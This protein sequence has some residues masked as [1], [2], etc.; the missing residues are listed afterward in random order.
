MPD[1]RRR[2][3]RWIDTN[4]NDQVAVAATSDPVA[5][6]NASVLAGDV[7]GLTIIRTLVD[8][9]FHPTVPGVA[10]GSMH[11]QIGAG[12]VTADAFLANSL[13]D[14]LSS[15]EEPV[16]GWMFKNARF[17]WDDPDRGLPY[18][19]SHLFLDI[20]SQRKLD[21]DTEV[22]WQWVNTAMAGASFA[23]EA[24]GLIRLLVKLP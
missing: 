23:V 18:D 6:L 9:S 17:C 3:T 20:H 22:Y 7:P 8:V 16:R 4:V 11:C 12:I 10:L 1:G 5:L 15:S 2:G 19:A 14:L 21:L 24:T 13:P